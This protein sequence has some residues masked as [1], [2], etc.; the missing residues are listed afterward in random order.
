M[1]LDRTL[2][3]TQDIYENMIFDPIK[4]GTLEA[5]SPKYVGL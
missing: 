3:C 5:A 4:D 1:Q 2:E